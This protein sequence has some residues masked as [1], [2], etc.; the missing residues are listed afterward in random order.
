MD[1]ECILDEAKFFDPAT[2]QWGYA[3]IC[4]EP[5]H[6]KRPEPCPSEREMFRLPP[7]IDGSDE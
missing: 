4:C 3:V 7:R 2:K 6:Q 5:S 1:D